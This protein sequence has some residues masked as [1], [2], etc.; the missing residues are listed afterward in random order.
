MYMECFENPTSRCLCN[1]WWLWIGFF[2]AYSNNKIQ[3]D[4]TKNECNKNNKNNNNSSQCEMKYREEKAPHILIIF[5]VQNNGLKTETESV[6]V[7]ALLTR[8]SSLINKLSVIEWTTNVTRTTN[9]CGRKRWRKCQSQGVWGGM[10]QN[11]NNIIKFIAEMRRK[12]TTRKRRKRRK[13]NYDKMALAMERTWKIIIFNNMKATLVLSNSLAH[14][15]THRQLIFIN[16]FAS[17]NHF[18]FHSHRSIFMV[19][20]FVPALSNPVL[21]LSL[22]LARHFNSSPVLDSV[23]LL[24]FNFRWVYSS[25]FIYGNFKSADFP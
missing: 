24:C 21:S 15:H 9:E 13:K 23:Y 1:W 25:H 8:N 17:L 3:L 22:S 19:F 10:Q 6:C 20:C 5:C 7:C 16:A 2:F 4:C 18:I 12:I 14:T 11:N